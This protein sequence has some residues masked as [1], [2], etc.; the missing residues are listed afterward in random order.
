[1]S[2]KKLSVG[3]MVLLTDVP[4]MG[5]AA[6]LQRRGEFNHEKMA[7]ESWPGACQVTAHG[8]VEV[9]ETC[10]QALYREISEEL[11]A[12]AVQVIRAQGAKVPEI[13]HHATDQKTVFTYGMVLPAS[14]LKC[15]QLGPSSGGLVLMPENQVDIIQNLNLFD[16]TEGVRDRKIVAMFPDEI[17]AVKKA[18]EILK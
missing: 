10:E 6:L 18:F 1:M 14:L 7:P 17:E 2:E 3:V 13:Y 5:R 16:K 12:L 11:G 8:K 9:Y 4:N 15:V